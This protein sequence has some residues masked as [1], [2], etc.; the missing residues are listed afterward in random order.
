MSLKFNARANG[1]EFKTFD[2]SLTHWVTNQGDDI[3]VQANS[4]ADANTKNKLRVISHTKSHSNLCSAKDLGLDFG[5]TSFVT[6]Q[7]N[8]IKEG[9]RV[10]KIDD[11]KRKI[12]PIFYNGV[13]MSRARV[14]ATFFVP[15]EE[16]HP[17]VAVVDGDTQNLHADNLYWSERNLFPELNHTYEAED[18]AHDVVIHSPHIRVLRENL[19]L[20]GW[21]KVFTRV[22][23]PIPNDLLMFFKQWKISIQS[24]VFTSLRYI[25]QWSFTVYSIEYKEGK[26]VFVGYSPALDGIYIDQIFKVAKDV[27]WLNEL[28]FTEGHGVLKVRYLTLSQ[29]RTEA[30]DSCV[31]FMNDYYNLG[32]EVMNTDFYHPDMVRELKVSLK[33]SELERLNKKLKKEK[34]V[35]LETYLN[36]VVRKLSK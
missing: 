21:E 29:T 2:Y 25:S 9:D 18:L 28:L 17:F 32:W 5:D 36:A 7:R 14:I 20:Y 4:N 22:S 30:H 12:N 31:R 34:G 24:A 8:T 6:R 19:N 1:I 13:K 11:G 15:N 10:V 3:V 23:V 26:K 35:D 33:Y 16:G 27:P